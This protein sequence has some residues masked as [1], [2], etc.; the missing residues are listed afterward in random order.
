MFDTDHNFPKRL[1][2]VV[3]WLARFCGSDLTDYRSGEVLGRA[4]LVP[5]RGKI[6]VIG[7]EHPVVP[8]FVHQDRLTYWKQDLSF[9]AHPPPDFPHDRPS[10]GAA[11]A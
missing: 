5:F 2:A 4:L 7:L 8:V 3:L 6:H 10:A 11:R 9:T 1:R